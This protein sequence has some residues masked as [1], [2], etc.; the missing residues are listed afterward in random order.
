[1]STHKQMILRAVLARSEFYN[2]KHETVLLRES[3][4]GLNLKSGARFVDA[5]LGMGG[6]SA[7]VCRELNGNVSIYGFD[8]DTDAL[9]HAKKILEKAGCTPTLFHDNFRNVDDVLTKNGVDAVEGVLFDLGVSSYQIDDS[10]RGFT[11]KKDEPLAMTMNKEKDKHVFTAMDVVNEWEEES[12]ANIIFA[13][14][15]ERYSRRIAKAIVAAR[16]KAPI[17]TTFDLVDVIS[18]AV[19]A[20]YRHGKIHPAT[21]TFQALRIV[22]ND[23]LGAL[24]QGLEAAWSILR[25]GGRIAAI[26]FHSL[27]DREV[28]QFMKKKVDAGEGKGITKKPIVPELTE[29][30]GNP[31]ARSA[32]LRIIEK[33]Q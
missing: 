26:S 29:T 4:L 21:R 10:G 30:K 13:Y 14:G 22:V 18:S 17:V 16:K 7:E 3:I 5:T 20:A 28:K 31:R 15:E 24:K 2:M 6:H 33:T 1:M 23:E 9:A 32:K 27:E 12:I 11:F 19:P 25:P 8:N